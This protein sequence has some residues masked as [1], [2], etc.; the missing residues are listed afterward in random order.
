MPRS[1]SRNSQ[2]LVGNAI[3]LS[4]TGLI[5]QAASSTILLSDFNRPPVRLK[6]CMGAC[7]AGNAA[8]LGACSDV[9]FQQK[10]LFDPPQVP[11]RNV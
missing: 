5:E 4:V 3:V 1:A 11:A 2:A 7:L 8:W 6:W 9:M 10:E